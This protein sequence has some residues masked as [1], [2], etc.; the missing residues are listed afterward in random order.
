MGW[1]DVGARVR[2]ARLAAGLTQAQLAHRIGLDR[3]AL[4]RV[5]AGDRRIDALELR[6]LSDA[7]ALPLPFLV[8]ASPDAIVSRRRP[9]T[10][11]VDI[12]GRSGFQ[13]DVRLEQHHLDA[14]Q[15]LALNHLTLPA[16]PELGGAADS[17]EAKVLARRVRQHLGVDDRPLGP[18]AEVCE[19]LALLVLVVPVD[20]E[21]ASLREDGYGVAVL[22][23]RADPGRRRAT[24]A[25][26]LGHHLLGD[27]YSNDI[28]IAASRDEREQVIETFA[29]EL[30]LPESAVEHA[31]AQ[32]DSL[33]L[34]DA[35]VRVAARWRV[36]WSMTLITAV[37]ALSLS[38]TARKQL[39]AAAPTRAEFIAVLGEAPQPDLEPGATGPRWRRAVLM[40]YGAGDM[41]AA[42]TVELLH[43]LVTEADLPDRA[44]LAD[45]W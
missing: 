31:G 7:L 19:R 8:T 14:Q 37:R 34:R 39:L 29:A 2:Q 6:V 41:T 13:L 45:R 3:S 12:V 20:A 23:D 24:A 42:R 43:G 32:T 44:E 9:L 28:G 40:A 26:E 17:A 38:D 4:A 25:H 18:M 1:S 21:G 5:E 11:T 36:S 27:E 10:E 33:T 35:L 30:L 15:L 16:R 22:G